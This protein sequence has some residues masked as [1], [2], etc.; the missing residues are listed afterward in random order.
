MKKKIIIHAFQVIVA[1]LMCAVNTIALNLPSESIVMKNGRPYSG[2]AEFKFA[3]ISGSTSL[4]SNDGTSIDASEPITSYAIQVTEGTYSMVI[5]EKPMKPF[6]YE[7]LDIYR[8][9]VLLTWVDTGEGFK[10][11]KKEPLTI[12]K[13]WSFFQRRIFMEK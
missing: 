3:V 8:S 11:F 6:F 9:A 4:W 7:I 10:L 12:S 2:I 5:G 1:F 13:M